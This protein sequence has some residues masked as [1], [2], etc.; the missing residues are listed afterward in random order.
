MD[1]SLLQMLPGDIIW[2]AFLEGVVR[3]K[4]ADGHIKD[5]ASGLPGV[6]SIAIPGTGVRW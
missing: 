1:G 3:M 6:N 4:S 5:L 2:T